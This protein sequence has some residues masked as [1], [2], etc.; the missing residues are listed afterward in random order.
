MRIGF[1]WNDWNLEHIAG[2]G[3]TPEEVE[4]VVNQASRPYP[5]AREDGKF[6]VHG[7]GQGGQFLQVIFVYDEDRTVYVIHARPMTDPEKR[8][9]RRRQK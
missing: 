4:M 6:L 9:Y 7:K 1:R 8:R 5:S 2:H 3:V